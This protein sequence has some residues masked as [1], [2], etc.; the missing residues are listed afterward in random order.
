[1]PRHQILPQPPDPEPEPPGPE[2]ED[3][4]PPDPNPVAR[5]SPAEGARH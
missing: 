1:M 5:A 4:L 2:P 3:P